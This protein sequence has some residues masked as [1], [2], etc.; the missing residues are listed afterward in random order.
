MQGWDIDRL[1]LSINDVVDQ[2]SELSTSMICAMTAPGAGLPEHV[3]LYH[4]DPRIQALYR[5]RPKVF[6]PDSRAYIKVPPV[7]LD[8]DGI[9]RPGA[10]SADYRHTPVEKKFLDGEFAKWHGAGLMERWYGT[11]PFAAACFPVDLDDES[12]HR[13]RAVINYRPGINKSLI[14]VAFPQPTISELLSQLGRKSIFSTFDLK[15]GYHQLRVDQASGALCMVRHGGVLWRPTRL[16]E[17]VSTAPSIFTSTMHDIN[18][19]QLEDGDLALYMD[20]GCVASESME[21]HLQEVDRFLETCERYDVRLSFAKCRFLQTELEWLGHTIKDGQVR[22]L[23]SYL[24]KL[25]DLPL[26]TLV[27]DLQRSLGMMVWVVRHLRGA[28]RLASP[29]YEMLEGKM[30]PRR[31]KDHLQWTPQLREVWAKLKELMLSPAVL[32]L[33][34]PSLPYHI[35]VDASE[36]G[37]GAGL[38]QMRHGYLV[39]VEFLSQRWKAEWQR[40]ACART[41]ELSALTSCTQYWASLIRNGHP[42]SVQSDHRSLSQLIQPRT[43]DEPRVRQAVGTLAHLNLRVDYVPGPM[44]CGPDWLSREGLLYT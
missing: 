6:D 24:S 5:K 28:V 10:F 26:P 1:L 33:P 41:L 40:K 37:F 18:Q 39:P 19:E 15:G 27:A 11:S 12:P 35:Q 16:F 13:P 3:E 29:L 36:L 7:H 32:T 43:D 9:V 4:P 8:W 34:D 30:T 17:G 20:D 22:P 25:Q 44:M 42:V 23:K 31:R 38:M 14:P 2:V 21:Q